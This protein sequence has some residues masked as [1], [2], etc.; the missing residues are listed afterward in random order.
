MSGDY[1]RWSTVITNDEVI[2]ISS[3]PNHRIQGEEDGSIF[4]SLGGRRWWVLAIYATVII[5]SPP[6]DDLYI[7][8]E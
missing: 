7:T 1:Q 3:S 5:H 8:G 4:F 2:T 6:N